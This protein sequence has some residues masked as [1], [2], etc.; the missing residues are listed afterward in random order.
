VTKLIT[1]AAPHL[2]SEMANLKIGYSRAQAP[3]VQSLSPEARTEVGLNRKL[4]NKLELACVVCKL[5]RL[6]GDG[7]VNL[8]SQWPI[9]CQKSGIPA[10]LVP[11]SHFEAMLSPASVKVI[12]DLAREKLTRW[13]MDEVEKAKKLLFRDPDERPS[14][15]RRGEE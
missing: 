13:D 7:L 6:D 2:G 4:D 5:K 3:F 12:G 10:V 14:F 1:V 15:F 9:D 8:G 11:V